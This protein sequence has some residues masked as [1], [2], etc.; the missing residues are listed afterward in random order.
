MTHLLAI[1]V[2]TME[3]RIK[4]YKISNP[5]KGMDESSL[6]EYNE[7]LYMIS[8]NSQNNKTCKCKSIY[9]SDNNGEIWNDFYYD[10]DLKEP[11]CEG[12]FTDEA[13]YTDYSVIATELI[14]DKYID[15]IGI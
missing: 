4:T 15:V 3:K 5:I 13:T 8:R 2:T 7:K 12:N 10:S 14:Y 9:I 1:T 11:V 6:T